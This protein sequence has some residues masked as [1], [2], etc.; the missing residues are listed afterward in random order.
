MIPKA[1]ALVAINLP[2]RAVH[3]DIRVTG[4]GLRRAL[5]SLFAVVA[6]CTFLAACSE[7]HS[8]N[9]G[10]SAAAQVTL[11][12]AWLIGTHNSYWVDRGVSTD[13][14]ASGVQE[15]LLDQLL[16]EHVRAI[17]L[18]VH[19][20]PSTPHRYRVYHTT[21]GNSLC[22]DFA[23][24]LR[25]L[26]LLQYA[27]PRHEVIH[28]IIELKEYTASNFD[29]DHTVE[30]LEAILESEIGR[31]MIRPRDIL[32][33]C[34]VRD[35][36]AEPDLLA[37]VDRGGWP[38]LAESRGRFVVTV[39]AN[40]DDLIPSIGTLDWATY[41]LHGS[42][43]ERSAFSMAS[44]WKLD[45][46]T[47][48]AKIQEELPREELDRARRRSAFLQIEDP[49]DANLAPFLDQRGLVRID[50]AFS[51]A[52]QSARVALGAQIM[53]TDTP[54]LQFD[55]RGPQQLVRPFAPELPAARI[56]EPGDWILLSAPAE[57]ETFAWSAADATPVSWLETVPSV[58]AT[59]NAL[60]CLAVARTEAE[61]A[62]SS[63][64]LCRGKVRAD[65]S[66]GSNGG[67]GDPDTE[68][69]RLQARVCRQGDCRWDIVPINETE[70]AATAIAVQ[71]MP[72]GDAECVQP[73]T[74]SGLAEPDRLAWRAVA[75]PECFAD[76][77]RALGLAAIDDLSPRPARFSPPV[78]N[79]DALFARSRIRS[80][81]R[82]QIVAAQD[83]HER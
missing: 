58:A 17:E 82:T 30:D 6:A 20:D 15:N 66:H 43:F 81:G 73:F 78:T 47:L 69:I 53:Q 41:A 37:C 38:T 65:R 57:S 33:R 31:W 62:V 24:C 18:D 71:I 14:F 35:G 75:E 1:R 42:L 4:R 54:W 10:D 28:V 29:A 79:R 51:V 77:L 39:L 23:D 45:W 46:D 63:Y 12:R 48:P 8:S 27:L 40:F 80:D 7:D 25:P 36:D 59:G 60:P 21:P 72:D 22:D 32:E 44:S 9:E 34:G 2:D 50:G 52:D 16:A 70:E 3:V 68:K 76:G 26:R 61:T 74:A 19:P 11:D 83:L 67:S 64:L 5:S 13:F 49:S 55:D 56:V